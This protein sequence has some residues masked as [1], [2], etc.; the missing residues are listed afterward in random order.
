MAQSESS[1]LVD[2]LLVDTAASELG[3]PVRC[4]FNENLGVYVAEAVEEE[5]VVCQGQGISPQV[6]LRNLKRS[7]MVIDRARGAGS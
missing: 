4:Q 3:V 1:K 6:A 7:F 2:V 5:Q